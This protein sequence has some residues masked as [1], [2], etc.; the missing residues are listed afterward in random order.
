MNTKE[1][2]ER[3]IELL[4]E[5]NF[6][7]IDASIEESL[8]CY[9][10][11]WSKEDGFTIICSGNKEPPYSYGVTTIKP[12]QILEAIEEQKEGFFKFLEIEK[13]E[14]IENLKDDIKENRNLSHYI[15]SVRQYNDLLTDDIYYTMPID[16]ILKIIENN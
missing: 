16:Y 3:L 9:G 1:K 10:L 12:C 5:K 11:L 6:K 13:N 7:G 14:Y 15:Y 4:E 8:F 2:E